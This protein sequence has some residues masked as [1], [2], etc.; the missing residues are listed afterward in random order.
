MVFEQQAQ[1]DLYAHVTTYMRSWRSRLLW[2]GTRLW[3]RAGA[4]SLASG[5]L[6]KRAARISS[7]PL[8]TRPSSQGRVRRRQR[9]PSRQHARQRITP[10]FTAVG[11]PQ[12][13]H[14]PR[15]LDL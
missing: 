11:E 6:S 13:L 8:L 10:G 1:I 7:V 4:G 12:L 3:R 15:Y 14:R 2:L 9:T 5:M